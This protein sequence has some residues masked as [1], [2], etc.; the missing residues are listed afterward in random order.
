MNLN[1]EID[2]NVF[3][4]ASRPHRCTQAQIVRAIKGVET[5]GLSI[6]KLEIGTDGSIVVYTGG[7]VPGEP[8][9]DYAVW[10]L[11]RRAR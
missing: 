8:V 1:N 2:K 11:E 4:G 5:A 3:R 6:G 7:A 10:K 9:D